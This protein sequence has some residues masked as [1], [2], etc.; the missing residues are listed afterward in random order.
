MS[1]LDVALKSAGQQG[2][3]DLRENAIARGV[4]FYAVW[5]TGFMLAEPRPAD[6]IAD[7]EAARAALAESDERIPY[8]KIR[9]ELGL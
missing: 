8:D 6:E 1:N 5:L 2:K 4:R 9:R 3:A 7:V